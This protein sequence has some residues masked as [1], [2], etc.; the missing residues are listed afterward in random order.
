M[1]STYHWKSEIESALET[2]VPNEPKHG[3]GERKFHMTP[4]WRKH[5]CQ[6]LK[7]KNNYQVKISSSLSNSDEGWINTLRPTHEKLCLQ[8]DSM[9]HKLMEVTLSSGT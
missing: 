2:Q 9:K 6:S 5:I 4:H 8:Q 1:I 7:G 3:G